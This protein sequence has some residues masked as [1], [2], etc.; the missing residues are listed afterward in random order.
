MQNVTPISVMQKF[1]FGQK[2]LCS[3][4]HE[5]T[6]TQVVFDPASHRMTTLGIGLGYMFKRNVYVPFE[7]VVTVTEDGI[8]LRITRATLAASSPVASV[9]ALLDSESVAEIANKGVITPRSAIHIIALHP[10][11]GE[12]AYLVVHHIRPGQDTLLSGKY[13]TQITSGCV[14]VSLLEETL[15]V[16]PQYHSDRELQK[17]VENRLYDLTSFHIDLKGMHIRV[18]DGVLYLAGNTS[19]SLRTDIVLDQTMDIE[20]LLEVKSELI[21]DDTLASGLAMALGHDS[22]THELPI[23][24]YPRLGNVRLSGSVHDEQQKTA[25]EHITQA[26]PG[27]RSV[28][29]TLVVNLK[30]DM[31]HAMASAEGGLGEDRIPGKYTRHTG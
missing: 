21:G 15:Q 10:E 17:E 29:N 27:V 4:G 14:K 23:G 13:V 30:E 11:S 5:G 3:D 26:Y 6:L 18:L 24:I 19:S 12:L 25:A 9:G 16:L 7:T 20:G 2:I 28:T 1:Q 31:L 8:A 22:R